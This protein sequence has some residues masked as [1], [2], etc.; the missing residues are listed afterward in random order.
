MKEDFTIDVINHVDY[1]LIEDYVKEKEQ[2]NKKRQAKRRTP[3]IKWVY[4]AACICLMTII[5]VFAISKIRTVDNPNVPPVVDNSS[6]SDISSGT[7]SETSDDTLPPNTDN[8]GDNAKYQFVSLVTQADWPYYNTAAEVVEASTHIYYGKVMDIS[9]AIIDQSTGKV[10]NS[11][12][13]S[14]SNRMLYTVYTIKVAESFKGESTTETKLCLSG[15]LIGYKEEEQYNLMKESGL[16]S[17]FKGIPVCSDN[18]SKLTVDKD[19]LFCVSRIGD[20]D[21]IISPTQSVYK[22]DSAYSREI[23]NA[24][25]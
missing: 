8:S 24:C 3:W 23:V 11:P 19:Y 21:E 25:N 22:F 9:F 12:Q 7:T 4:V 10:N 13:T 5:T 15:G 20:F 16:L 6:D 1:D 14:N 18:Y 17:V 2:L